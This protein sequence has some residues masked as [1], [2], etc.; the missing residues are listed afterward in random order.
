MKRFKAALAAA[1]VAAL[2][3]VVTL[4]IAMTAPMIPQQRR[5]PTPPPARPLQ[6]PYV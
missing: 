6:L 3:A 5:L 2:G 4:P 1:A